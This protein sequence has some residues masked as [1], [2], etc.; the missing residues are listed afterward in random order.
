MK[1]G[2]WVPLDKGA[3]KYLPHGRAYT[4]LEALFSYRVDIDNSTEKSLSWYSK[5]WGWSRNKVRSFTE[6]LRTGEGHLMDRKGTSKGQA[7]FLKINNLGDKKDRKRTEE[8]QVKDSKRTASNKPNPKPEPKPREKQ[9]IFSFEEIWK[10]YPNRDGR[11]QAEKS[12][13]ASV[14]TGQDWRDINT[15]L[16]NYLGSKNVL[17]GFIKNGSTWFNNWRDWVDWNEIEMGPP[18]LNPINMKLLEKYGR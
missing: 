12:F 2:N 14:K 17:K 8:G 7:I 10:K 3:V 9:E 13:N 16:E 4:K 6:D 5:Q 11:K 15:A 1:D 18:K